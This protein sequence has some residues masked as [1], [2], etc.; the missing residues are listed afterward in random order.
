M[1]QIENMLIHLTANITDFLTLLMVS[2]LFQC[3]FFMTYSISHL[4]HFIRHFSVSFFGLMFN[5]K[6]AKVRRMKA[7]K[8]VMLI[9]PSLVMGLIL[10][11][12]I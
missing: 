12:I 11:M 9:V 4:S 3:N 8:A 10:I 7:D 5:I 6:M 2:S 1:A